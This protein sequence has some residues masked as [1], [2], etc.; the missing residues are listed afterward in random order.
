MTGQTPSKGKQTMRDVDAL[1]QVA[2][3]LGVDEDAQRKAFSLAF[4]FGFEPERVVTLLLPQS[5]AAA[6]KRLENQ[7]C[8]ERNLARQKT[9]AARKL[10]KPNA[11]LLQEALLETICGELEKNPEKVHPLQRYL[12]RLFSYALLHGS[13]SVAVA[14]ARILSNGGSEREFLEL[15]RRTAGHVKDDGQVRATTRKLLKLVFP[16]WSDP[17]RPNN[18]IRKNEKPALDE[19]IHDLLDRMLP[20]NTD[21]LDAGKM[22]E[23][24]VAAGPDVQHDL[25]VSHWFMDHRCC[26]SKLNKAELKSVVFDEWHMPEELSSPNSSPPDKPMHGSN[27]FDS[28]T[29]QLLKNLK[30]SGTTRVAPPPAARYDIVIDGRRLASVAYPGTSHAS[31]RL[32]PEDHLLEVKAAGTCDVV[33]TCYVMDP[34]DL[35]EEGWHPPRARSSAS[36]ATCGRAS[37]TRW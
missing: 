11:V 25:N 6:M 16:E 31:L 15:Y 34:D 3:Y 36:T 22:G 35:P 32:P 26:V 2:W 33:A 13:F 5:I 19:A 7:T 10:V 27:N 18:S 30:A 14:S 37:T 1:K 21:H 24:R 23:L 12:V 9:R 4:Y 20:W 29:L 8:N 28:L 17:K